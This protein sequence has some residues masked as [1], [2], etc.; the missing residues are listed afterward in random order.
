ML[1]EKTEEE[2]AEEAR[3]AQEEADAKMKEE[4]SKVMDLLSQLS[5]EEVKT[6]MNEVFDDML[7]GVKVRDK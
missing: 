5:T 4:E 2:L 6:I 3:L 7:G 1:Q